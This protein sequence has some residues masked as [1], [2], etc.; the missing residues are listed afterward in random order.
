MEQ[1]DDCNVNRNRLG[2]GLVKEL[3][4]LEI[5]GQMETIQATALLKLARIHVYWDTLY[6]NLWFV[7]E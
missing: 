7:K 4:N 6:I 2:K 1:E 3:E 5:R